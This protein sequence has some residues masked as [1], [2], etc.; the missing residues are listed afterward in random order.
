MT[1]VVIQVYGDNISDEIFHLWNDEC[2][3]TDVYGA[4][5]QMFFSSAE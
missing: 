3:Y 5:Y 4:I 2:C 1:N